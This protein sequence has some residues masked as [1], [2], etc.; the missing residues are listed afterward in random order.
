[1]PFTSEEIRA[2]NDS[3]MAELLKRNKAAL[4]ELMRLTA[5]YGP[6]APRPPTIEDKARDLVSYFNCQTP[7]NY[8]AAEIVQGLLDLIDEERAYR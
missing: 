3:A 6:P 1:M 2:I 5:E 4:L 8:H 7:P